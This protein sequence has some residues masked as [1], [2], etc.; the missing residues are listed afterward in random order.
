ML[1]LVGGDGHRV[2]RML[3]LNYDIYVSLDYPLAWRGS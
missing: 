3:D 1:V 2:T